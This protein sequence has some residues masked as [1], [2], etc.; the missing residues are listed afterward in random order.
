[1]LIDD[2]IDLIYGFLSIW[3]VLSPEI[4]EGLLSIA[5]TS[6]DLTYYLPRPSPFEHRGISAEIGIGHH[7]R[8]S[9]FIHATRITTRGACMLTKTNKTDI[10][11]D[12]AARAME[13]GCRHGRAIPAEHGRS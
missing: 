8:D 6:I 4:E 7:M 11:L 10:Y 3:Q 5:L 13:R 2:L 12:I 1:V 9:L